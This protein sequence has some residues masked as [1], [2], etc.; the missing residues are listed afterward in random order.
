M[1][2]GLRCLRLP[3]MAA[4]L[5]HSHM[6]MITITTPQSNTIEQQH[7]NRTTRTGRR[8]SRVGWR[9]IA[10]PSIR[11]RRYTSYKSKQSI[12][13]N[14]N[15]NNSNNILLRCAHSLHSHSATPSLC[16]ILARACFC[17]QKKKKKNTHT[18]VKKI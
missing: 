11:S 13:N 8:R 18:F 15:N 9:R 12:L 5:N 2:A 1:A 10:A 6:I 17:L 14:N 3:E 4:V 7:N 16:T